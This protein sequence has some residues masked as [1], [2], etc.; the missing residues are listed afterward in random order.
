VERYILLCDDDFVLTE[1]TDLSGALTVLQE[2][3]DIG[4]VG[5]ACSTISMTTANPFGI[6]SYSC[7]LIGLIA[8]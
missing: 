4:V 6:G 2:H 1:S 3:N 8:S 5:G 7:I